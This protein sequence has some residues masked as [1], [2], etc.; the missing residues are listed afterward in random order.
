M[1]VQKIARGSRLTPLGV[2]LK[3]RSNGALQ[4]VNLTSKTV[5]V[6]V[7]DGR[8]SIIVAETT[9]GVTVVNASAGQVSY[10][11]PAAVYNRTRGDCSVY[12]NVYGSGGDSTKY[13]TYPVPENHPASQMIV[14]VYEPL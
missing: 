4:A 2:Y 1:P 5:K 6:F 14:S 12:F 9:T 11:L 3:Q 10:A 8:G 13:D 7:T